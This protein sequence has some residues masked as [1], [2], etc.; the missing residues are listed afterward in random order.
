MSRRL[1]EIKRRKKTLVIHRVTKTGDEQGIGQIEEILASGL[2]MD[3][4]TC[5]ESN[6]H[7]ET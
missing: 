5:G 2:Y 1:F 7:W 4:E 3:F 6:K